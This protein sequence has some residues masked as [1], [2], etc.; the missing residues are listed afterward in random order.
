MSSLPKLIATASS[1][2]SA[3]ESG[4]LQA[5][6]APLRP[7]QSATEKSVALAR[8]KRPKRGERDMGTPTAKKVIVLHH[9]MP[10]I[11]IDRLVWRESI[12]FHA[13][14]IGLLHAPIK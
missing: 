6:N 14:L 13:D 3:S 8:G 4:F 7:R 2:L 1:F 12:F 11:D 5:I 9:E 10:M